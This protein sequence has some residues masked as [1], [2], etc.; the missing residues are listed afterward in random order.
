MRN[1]SKHILK[2]H[3]QNHCDFCDMSCIRKALLDG[4][5]VRTKE[6]GKG[7][8]SRADGGGGGR[9]YQ[10]NE[11]QEFPAPSVGLMRGHFDSL[12]VAQ[13]RAVGQQNRHPQHLARNKRH[14]RQGLH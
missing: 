9:P 8:E 2:E 13:D 7:L 10:I 4:S 5:G 12:V 6:K 11:R 3:V 14:V 1:D